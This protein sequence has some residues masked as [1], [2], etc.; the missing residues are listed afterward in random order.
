MRAD[1][2]GIIAERDEMTRSEAK[3]IVDEVMAEIMA[4]VDAGEFS[5]AEQ[6][7]MD[8]LGLEMDYLID[9]L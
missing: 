5:A 2:I 7:F 9:I 3:E 4:H 6:E 1:V 8:G